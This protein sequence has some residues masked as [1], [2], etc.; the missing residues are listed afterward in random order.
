LNEYENGMYLL[1]IKMDKLPLITKWFVVEH[2][3]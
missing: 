2:L 3:K 1:T